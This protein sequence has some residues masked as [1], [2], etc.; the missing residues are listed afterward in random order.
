MG[1]CLSKCMKNDVIKKSVHTQTSETQV[2]YSIQSSRSFR[3]IGPKELELYR[4][5]KTTPIRSSLLS[6]SPVHSPQISLRTHPMQQSSFAHQRKSFSYNV[7]SEPPIDE[8]SISIAVK[9]SSYDSIHHQP[10]SLH[11]GLPWHTS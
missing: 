11:N 8:S 9:G 6:N 7:L 5:S 4:L 2:E 3:I 10:Y 1:S